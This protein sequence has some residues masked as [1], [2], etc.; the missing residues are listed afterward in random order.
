MPDHDS[1]SVR[2]SA[3][4]KN[5]VRRRLRFIYLKGLRL[6][7]HPNELA[8]GMALGIGIG[9]MPIIP[10]QTMIAVTLAILFGASKITAAAGTWISNPVTVYHVYKYCYLIGSFILGFD[11][12][13]KHLKPMARAIGQVEYLEVIKIILSGGSKAVATFLLGGIVLGLL[14][15]VPSYVLSYYCFK[16]LHAWR[17]SRKS[18]K[19]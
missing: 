14:A 15:A 6:R 19:A 7:G 11:H 16:N 2:H 4:S 9:M 18:K 3:M 5:T 8:L 17:T 12:H 1:P 10:F 13:A